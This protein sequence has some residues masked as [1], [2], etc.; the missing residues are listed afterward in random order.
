L[1]S[2]ARSRACGA[3]LPCKGTSEWSRKKKL[4]P[5]NTA[6]IVNKHAYQLISVVYETNRRNFSFARSARIFFCIRSTRGSTQGAEYCR[7]GDFGARLRRTVGAQGI[8]RPREVRFSRAEQPAGESGGAHPRKRS[9]GPVPR[10]HYRRTT[11]RGLAAGPFFII[12]HG[13]SRRREPAAVRVCCCA[14]GCAGRLRLA[15]GSPE[16]SRQAPTKKPAVRVCC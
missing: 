12:A 13:D 3:G 4:N 8:R 15:A 11:I 2:P 10:P 14:A 1:R 5:A 16:G 6:N 7:S 9:H